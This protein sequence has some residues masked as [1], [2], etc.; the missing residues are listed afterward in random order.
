MRIHHSDH[1]P[2]EQLER[3]RERERDGLMILDVFQPICRIKINGNNPESTVTLY[4]MEDKHTDGDD[5][6]GTTYNICIT[7]DL[8][9][10]TK[11]HSF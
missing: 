7:E 11:H 1:Q 10:Y 6:K 9:P 3:S 4:E 2:Q 8:S 5:S